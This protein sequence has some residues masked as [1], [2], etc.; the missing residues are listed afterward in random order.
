MRRRLED[1]LTRLGTDHLDAYAYHNDDFGQGDQ[2]LAPALEAMRAFQDE[3]LIRMTSMR[4]PHEFVLEWAEIPGHPRRTETRRFLERFERLQPAFLAARHN[5]TSVTAG[6]GQTDLN[7][8]ARSRQVTVLAKQ[9]LAQGLLTLTGPQT[10]APVYGSGDHRAGKAAFSAAAR[11]VY[12]SHLDTVRAALGIPQSALR[13]WPSATPRRRCPEAS[14]D[15][16]AHRR[17]TPPVPA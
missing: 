17:T 11:Q 12:A 6:P 15:R 13:P 1:T 8:F 5:M 4:A 16:P 14:S 3:G 2:W 7:A 9:V 10:T